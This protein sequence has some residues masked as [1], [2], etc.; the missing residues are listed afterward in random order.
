MKLR[1]VLLAT[2]LAASPVMAQAAPV[3]GFFTAL[4]VG[5]GAAT[6][7]TDILI[8]I[9]LTAVTSLLSP[10]PK[11]PTVTDAQVNTRLE[12]ATR[13]QACGIAAVGGAAGCFAEYDTSNN[14]WYIIA[15]ADAELAGQPTYILDGVTVAVSDGTDGFTAG[16]V[17]TNQFCLDR[18]GA[19][20]T[21]TGTKT[22]VFRLYTVTPSSSAVYG[23]LPAAFTAAFPTLPADFR[24]AGVAFTIVR[25][26]AQGA[27][28]YR[29]AM[30]WHGPLGLGEPSVVLVG[31]WNRMYDPRNAAHDINTPSTWTASNGNPAILWA[32]WRT[33][34]YGRNRPMAEIN[35]TRVAAAA[36]ICDQTVLDRFGTTVPLYRC[37]G[38]FPDSAARQDC[39]KQILASFDAFVAYDEAGLAYPVPGYYTTPTLQFTAARDIISAQ[40]Q[41]TD[42]GETAVDGVI[43]YYTE[44][45]LG[46]TRQPCAPWKNADW[47]DG[48][49]A[50]N[51]QTFD[52]LTCQNPNQA[53]RL[54]K[55][56][57]KRIAPTQRAA[58]GTTIKGILAKGQAVID[59]Q[60]DAT[61]SGSY[62]IVSPVEE[63]ESGMACGFSVVP[64]ATDRWYL[65]AGEEGLPPA[66]TPSVTTGGITLY[67]ASLDSASATGGSG[68]VTVTFDTP[69]NPDQSAVVIY[70]GSTN[71]FSAA[72]VTATTYAIPNFSGYAT[73]TGIAA[74]T[75]YIWAAPQN[76]SR[77]NGSASG[78]FTV[79][80][81]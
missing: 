18:H 55:A 69:N 28:T 17:T 49:S 63:N 10:K 40:T 16:D 70:R 22:P 77:I 66:T 56:M 37:G 12:T 41:I 51:Y 59:L 1:T 7:L 34:R 26:A 68:Q 78:P 19:T 64:V 71:V 50:P 4:G 73:E 33:T 15:H 62:E 35:W 38:A 65:N 75:W 48:T 32:W 27:S 24:L 5:A 46:Y 30:K 44:P 74:G 79:T 25:C 13:W 58:L 11:G 29:N 72:T 81:T 52:V 80:V 36:A 3:I 23:A 43:V 21:G 57:G 9:A 47:Y 45:T 20:Y 31:N 53:V 8:N 6:V 39:E 61:F 42:D 76:T 67:N 14:L 2:A 54:A 60:Y